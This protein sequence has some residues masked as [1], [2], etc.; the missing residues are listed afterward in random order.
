MIRMLLLALGLLLAAVQPGRAQADAGDVEAGRRLAGIWCSNCHLTGAGPQ[1]RT[2]DAAPSFR[3]I[4]RMPSQTALSLRAFL[5]TPHVLMPDYQL[6]REEQ[7]DV[8]AY[9][10]SLDDRRQQT[11]R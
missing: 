11:K 3:S 1:A 4:A 8:V 6:S 7:D 5:Q 10:L 2:A 9:I